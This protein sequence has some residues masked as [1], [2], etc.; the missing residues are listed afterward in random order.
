MGNP[1]PRPKSSGVTLGSDVPLL[2]LFGGG[3]NPA[4]KLAAEFGQFRRFVGVLN[5]ADLF[6]RF[7]G[8]L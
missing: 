8:F 7:V 1:P 3:F 2:F 5:S 6:C 4:P